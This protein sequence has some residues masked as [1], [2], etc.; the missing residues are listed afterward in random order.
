MSQK[1]LWIT[2]YLAGQQQTVG[3]NQV[4]EVIRVRK[5]RKITLIYGYTLAVQTCCIQCQS[6]CSGFFQVGFDTDNGQVGSLG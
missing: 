2:G 4:G 1:S 5:F 3:D 6:C